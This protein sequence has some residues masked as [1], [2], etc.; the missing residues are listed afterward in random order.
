MII[1]YGLYSPHMSQDFELRIFSH[2]YF[3]GLVGIVTVI[4]NIEYA[5]KLNINYYKVI[6]HRRSKLLDARQTNS[7]IFCILLGIKISVFRHTI[8]QEQKFH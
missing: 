3:D 1:G 2:D 7:L 6:D 5:R 8:L 4:L